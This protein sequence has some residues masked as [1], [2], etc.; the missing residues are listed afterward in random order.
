ME[1]N[2]QQEKHT[3]TTC[4]EQLQLARAWLELQTARN[5]LARIRGELGVED[6]IEIIDAIDDLKDQE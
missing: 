4:W 1:V 3:A 2:A 6:D 5:L